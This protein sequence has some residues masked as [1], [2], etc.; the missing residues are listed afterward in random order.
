[1][2]A[3]G[4]YRAFKLD[5]LKNRDGVHCVMTGPLI[6]EGPISTFFSANGGGKIKVAG[7]YWLSALVSI[8][9]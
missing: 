9:G 2:E 7:G 3:W 6:V 4:S 1:M 5:L 8:H